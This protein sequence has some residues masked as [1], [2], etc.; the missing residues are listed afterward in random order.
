MT[1]TLVDSN[2]LIDV[3]DEA[4]Q[5][6]EW[7]S[8]RLKEAANTGAIVINQ[9]VLAEASARFTESEAADAPA[10]SVFIRENLP[11]PAAFLAG[12]AH[13]LYRE[14]GGPRERSLPDFLIGAHA[15]TKQYHLLTRDP[16]RYRQYF[17]TLD[18]IAP[19]THP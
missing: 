12:Q 11:W 2:V 7:S 1:S 18:I 8:S 19:D 13:R 4:S 15:L 9:V 6:F 5:W 10:F 14:R 3:I 16:R 17:P